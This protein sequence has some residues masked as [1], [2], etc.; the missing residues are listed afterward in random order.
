[1]AIV[2]GVILGTLIF[3]P[4]RLL[5]VPSPLVRSAGLV[6]VHLPHDLAH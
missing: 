3:Q 6:L 1:M 4:Q 5:G 2:V